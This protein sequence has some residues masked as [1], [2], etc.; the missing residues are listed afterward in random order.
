MDGPDLRPAKK[1]AMILQTTSEQVRRWR[2]Q[3]RGPAYIRMS[4]RQIR[5]DVRDVEAWLEKQKIL[6]RA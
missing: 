5:Y 3:G 1:V 6:P 4:S 2:K